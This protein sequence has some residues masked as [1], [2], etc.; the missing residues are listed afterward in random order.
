MV[1]KKANKKHTV[2]T[3]AD[4]IKPSKKYL[5][6]CNCIY[7]NGKKLI[8]ALR[9][10]IRKAKVCGNVKFLEKIKKIQLKQKERKNQLL[11]M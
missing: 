8:L 10:N 7:C 5:Y 4:L 6:K 1:I 11:Q 2:E 9:K 3:V